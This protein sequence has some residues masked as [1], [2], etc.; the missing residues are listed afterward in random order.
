MVPQINQ[1]ARL[2]QEPKL[3]KTEIK[4][5][6]STNVNVAHPNLTDL[7]PRYEYTRHLQPGK[8]TITLPSFDPQ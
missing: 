1:T 6:M 8:L 2:A 7:N 5:D 4:Q 3:A